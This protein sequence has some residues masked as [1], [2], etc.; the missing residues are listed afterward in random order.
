VPTTGLGPLAFFCF[1]AMVL[2]PCGLRRRLLAPQ[3][4]CLPVQVVNFFSGYRHQESGIFSTIGWL[5]SCLM[6]LIDS[7]GIT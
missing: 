5:D 1:R 4:A 7:R 6:V 3:R 2:N